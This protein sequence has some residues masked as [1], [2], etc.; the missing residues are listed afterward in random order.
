MGCGSGSLSRFCSI[1]KSERVCK[2]VGRGFW[3][4]IRLTTML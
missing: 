1:C 2:K 3:K 4:D